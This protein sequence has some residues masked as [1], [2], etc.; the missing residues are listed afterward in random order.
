MAL[1]S[2]GTGAP[3]E[4]QPPGEL[5]TAG[6]ACRDQSLPL[7]RFDRLNPRGEAEPRF[8]SST[9]GDLRE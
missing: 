8:D 2:G 6:R 1:E 3:V 4:P 9:R 7:A 5:A